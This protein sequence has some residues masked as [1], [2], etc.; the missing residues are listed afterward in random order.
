MG[1]SQSN[2]EIWNWTQE[3][4]APDPKCGLDV[5]K[6]SASDFRLFLRI[7]LLLFAIMVPW[8]G[9]II[10]SNKYV[11][12][13][14]RTVSFAGRD[15]IFDIC[16]GAINGCRF[17][18]HAYMNKEACKV[19]YIFRL[20]FLGWLYAHM[21]PAVEHHYHWLNALQLENSRPTKLWLTAN[22]SLVLIWIRD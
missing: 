1:A 8:I 22:N 16:I 18:L 11:A 20:G 10:I 6:S 19:G 9:G 21:N 5:Q 13:C 4:N 17:W 3:K 2:R 12:F 15:Y 14:W 7:P